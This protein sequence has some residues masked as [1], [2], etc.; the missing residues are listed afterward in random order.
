MPIFEYICQA[1]GQPFEKLVSSARAVSC[2]ACASPRVEKQISAFAVAKTASDSVP[3][4]GSTGCGIERGGCGSG[5][6]GH[7]HS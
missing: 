4:C 2:P 1:C 5:L 7:H 3:D 6:C